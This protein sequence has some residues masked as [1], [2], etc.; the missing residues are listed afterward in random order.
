[1]TTSSLALAA[2]TGL[3]ARAGAGT[4]AALLLG[5]FAL[6]AAGH[7]VA[8]AV[9]PALG[10]APTWIDLAPNLAIV[11]IDLL[12]LAVVAGLLRR[13]GRTLR[14]LVL[15]TGLGRA[16]GA[17]L[18]TFLILAVAFVAFT[19]VGNLAAYG[20]PPPEVAD[21]GFRPPLWFALWSMA[22]M[23][24]TVALAEEALYRG[25][26]QPRLAVRVGR[27]P[28][29]AV[30][31]AAFGLQHVAFELGGDPRAALARLIITAGVG[32]LLGALYA[33]RGRLLPLIVAH[34]LLDVLGLGLPILL[35][36][37]AG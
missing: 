12:T 14:S 30:V 37:L 17:G 9:V 27:V 21:T 8:A 20:G 2:R 4:L 33:W 32:L 15:D 16:V 11:P 35:W 34:W 18:L 25:Y 24:V 6:L 29:V 5:R 22:V 3:V 31:A 23:P 36:S 1:M 19:I 28:A 7:A 13:E 10:L 26:V